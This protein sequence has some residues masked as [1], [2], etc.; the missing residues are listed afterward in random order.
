MT[1]VLDLFYV[2]LCKEKIIQTRE[3]KERGLDKKDQSSYPSLYAQNR[4]LN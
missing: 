2:W 1:L 3:K 4:L